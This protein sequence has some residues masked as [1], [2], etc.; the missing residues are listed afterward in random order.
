MSQSTEM[1]PLVSLFFQTFINPLKFLMLIYLLF[2][3]HTGFVF[4]SKYVIRKNVT[5]YLH[6]QLYKDRCIYVYNKRLQSIY[7]YVHIQ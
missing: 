1:P 7:T 4:K 3:R 5:F 6:L 2:D